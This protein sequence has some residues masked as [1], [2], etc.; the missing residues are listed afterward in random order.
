MLH[1]MMSTDRIVMVN[2]NQH[3]SFF[4]I[5]IYNNVIQ[6]KKKKQM[7]FSLVIVDRV[8]EVAVVVASL[9]H[10]RNQSTPYYYQFVYPINDSMYLLEHKPDE[11]E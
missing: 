11:I 8:T 1:R 5:I 3:K 7:N 6:R 9:K 2:S 10:L 4:F